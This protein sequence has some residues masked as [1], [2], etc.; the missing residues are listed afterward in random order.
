M[1]ALRLFWPDAQAA[2]VAPPAERHILRLYL[3]GRPARTQ[4][5]MSQVERARLLHDNRSCP[6][7]HR[8]LVEPIELQDALLTRNRLPIPGTATLVGFRCQHCRTEWPA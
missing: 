6:D 1:S 4:S 7:C 3:P 5:T 2:A 8:P